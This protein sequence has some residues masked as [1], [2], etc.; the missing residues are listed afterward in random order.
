MGRWGIGNR[1]SWCHQ[2]GAAMG[3]SR[4]SGRIVRTVAVACAAR[5]SPP[6]R[7]VVRRSDCRAIPDIDGAEYEP[8]KSGVGRR[9]EN[10]RR[11]KFIL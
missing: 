6:G 10:G 9:T 2:R 5:C 11:G 7:R 4:G 3:M 8:K 1:L